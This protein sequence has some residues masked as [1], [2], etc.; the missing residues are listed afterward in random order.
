ME[1]VLFGIIQNKLKIMY[2]LQS[3]KLKRGFNF[4]IY[5][6]Y[7]IWKIVII[8]ECSYHTEYELVPSKDKTRWLHK[9]ME[10]KTY[11]ISRSWKKYCNSHGNSAIGK[12]QCI[13]LSYQYT[14]LN[15]NYQNVKHKHWDGQDRQYQSTI[16]TTQLIWK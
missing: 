2:L 10:K 15:M 13:F 6:L 8:C 5:L 12:L 14:M 9:N 11:S 4:Y 16:P 3:W 7:Y 1:L